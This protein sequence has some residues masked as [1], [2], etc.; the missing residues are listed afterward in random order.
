M[1]HWV[2]VEACCV[3]DGRSCMRTDWMVCWI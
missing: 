1:Q 3:T 2:K